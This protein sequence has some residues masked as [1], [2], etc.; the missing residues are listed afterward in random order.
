MPKPRKKRRFWE[1]EPTVFQ[2][3]PKAGFFERRILQPFRF[4]GKYVLFALALTY[5]LSLVIVGIAF[6]GLVFWGFFVCSVAIIGVLITKLGYARNFANRDLG[7]R[8][9]GVLF[10]AFLVAMSYYVGLIY[11]KAWFLPIFVTILA[12]GLVLFLRRSKR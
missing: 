8:D 9:F 12:C 4:V 6:G 3:G 1:I 2:P 7:F 5:P 10:L 11:L